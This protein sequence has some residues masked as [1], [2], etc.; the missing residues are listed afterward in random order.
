MNDTSEKARAFVSNT[1]SSR[2]T[3][4][5]NGVPAC[6]FHAFREA[7]AGVARPILAMPTENRASTTIRWS[8][9]DNF[10]VPNVMLIDEIE[11]FGFASPMMTRSLTVPALAKCL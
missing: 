9:A 10:A 11:V 4:E 5:M 1:K 3:P 6:R 2:S 8:V 7:S